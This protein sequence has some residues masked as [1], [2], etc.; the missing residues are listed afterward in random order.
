ML[1][2][3]PSQGNNT[4]FKLPIFQ[5]SAFLVSFWCLV[6]VVNDRTNT[7]F[8]S[9]LLQNYVEIILSKL[10]TFEVR[11][12][13]MSLE[14]CM[15]EVTRQFKQL[16]GEVKNLNEMNGEGFKRLHGERFNTMETLSKFCLNLSRVCWNFFCVAFSKLC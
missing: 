6:A 1:V 13:E 11:R 8:V 9:T 12:R 16:H 10:A 3:H 4:L 5:S 2:K 15:P 7:I 14:S